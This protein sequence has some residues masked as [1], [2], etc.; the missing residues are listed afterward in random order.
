MLDLHLSNRI[1]L[2]AKVR[3]HILI[4]IWHLFRYNCSKVLVLWD[5]AT[6]PTSGKRL[7]RIAYVPD[8]ANWSDVPS[9]VKYCLIARVFCRVHV[10]AALTSSLWRWWMMHDLWLSLLVLTSI[11]IDYLRLRRCYDHLSRR[12]RV[13]IVNYTATR[14]CSRR[15][16]ASSLNVAY[17]LNLF[18]S[19]MIITCYGCALVKST[20]LQHLF[21]RLQPDKT[22]LSY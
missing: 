8:C 4:E 16:G 14:R 20:W 9:W 22:V 21:G 7:L 15:R 2:T 13:W 5:E 18:C 1:I 6:L 17:C 10:L 11:G 3:M 12:G 19:G